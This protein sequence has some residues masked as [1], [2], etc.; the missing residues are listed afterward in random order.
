[1]ISEL[2]DK[3][4]LHEQLIAVYNIAWDIE[5]AP[6]DMQKLFE[7]AIFC[8]RSDALCGDDI[9]SVDLKTEEQILKDI[10]FNS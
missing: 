4:S 9:S 7:A 10:Y 1:M 3:K 8:G 2:R 6:E 5:M